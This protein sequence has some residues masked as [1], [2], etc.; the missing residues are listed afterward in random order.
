MARRT[1]FSFHYERDVQRAQIVKNSWITKPDRDDAGFFDSSVFESKKRT[2]D[3]ALK[4]FLNEGMSGSSV[5]CVLFGTNTAW[6]RWVR[7][8]LFRS[9]ID[10]RGLL[11][12]AVH[13]ILGFD[14]RPD[15]QGANP[16]SCL[17]FEVLQGRVHFKEF[18]GNRWIW[19]KD[20]GSVP[21][22]TLAS[23]IGSHTN[24]TFDSLFRSYD[25]TS[26]GGYN[27]LGSWIESAAQAVG[28]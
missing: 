26:G 17:G 24:R 1:F 16:F 18:D 12:V 11:A 13:T 20:I 21:L 15:P 27:N 19:S 23:R 28:R 2:S 3:D 22:S 8:E 10:G 7:Y 6:R 5:A 9:F 14:R 4:R 25:W